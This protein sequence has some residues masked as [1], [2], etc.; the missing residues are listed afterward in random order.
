MTKETM[1]MIDRYRSLL[2]E[3]LELKIFRGLPIKVGNIGKIKQ[4][5]LDEIVS[6]E[7]GYM[8]YVQTLNTMCAE[9]DNVKEDDIYES[10]YNECYNET[11]FSKDI[12][13]A[14]ELY[15]GEKVEFDSEGFNV[16]GIG[17]NRIINKS[18]FAYVRKIIKTINHVAPPKE[19]EMP[20]FANKKAEMM[21]KQIQ[22]NQ[23]KLDKYKKHKSN[24]SS[25]ISGMAWKSG[26]HEKVW[27]LTV[28][29]LYDG[30]IR[31]GVI[32]E[33][34][35]IMSGIYAGTVDAKAIKK[36]ELDWTKIIIN[37]DQNNN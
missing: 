4:F 13:D 28:Y 15:F 8:F 7:I 6:D 12:I 37:N 1:E 18:N 24:L 5:T 2:D 19:E 16:G 14:L 25:L 23:K 35:H 3:D 36:E 34:H 31:I 27:D 21:W 33:T 11:E 20:I 26:L 29:K 32:D 22:E 9:I 10:F 17:S 30:L